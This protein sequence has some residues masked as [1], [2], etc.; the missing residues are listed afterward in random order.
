[1]F[2]SAVGDIITQLQ[3]NTNALYFLK[4]QQKLGKGSESLDKDD[5]LRMLMIKLQ[6]QDP[7]NPQKEEFMQQLATLSSVESLKNIEKTMT[8]NSL[9]TQAATMVGKTVQIKDEGGNLISGRVDSV[10][11]D[12]G[13][14][15]ISVGGRLYGM[16]SVVKISAEPA[17]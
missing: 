15:A 1:M 13:T 5:F 16:N 8:G 3:T 12:K 14:A 11:F 6:N 7:M 4:G 17:S 9:L 10:S 2:P